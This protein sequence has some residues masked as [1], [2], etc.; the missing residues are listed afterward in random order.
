[1]LLPGPVALGFSVCTDPPGPSRLDNFIPP[2]MGVPDGAGVPAEEAEAGGPSTLIPGVAAVAGVP[3]AG[4]AGELPPAF[5][6]LA[7]PKRS[8]NGLGKVLDVNGLNPPGVSEPSG[9]EEAPGV[10]ADADV[11]AGAKPADEVGLFRLDGVGVELEA[12]SPV[13]VPRLLL[14]GLTVPGTAL[15]L[16]NNAV[17]VLNLPADS[18]LAPSLPAAPEPADFFSN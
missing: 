4:V 17:G 1:M 14:S 18:S 15:G 13:L 9:L 6:P 5:A 12:P 2:E 11:E 7:E 16:G 8:P 3:D 10:V